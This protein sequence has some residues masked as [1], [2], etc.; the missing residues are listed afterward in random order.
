LTN[1]FSFRELEAILTVRNFMC[2][3]ARFYNS[4]TERLCW[5]MLT[6]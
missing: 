3:S 2:T 5:Y 6:Q 1:P 4:T